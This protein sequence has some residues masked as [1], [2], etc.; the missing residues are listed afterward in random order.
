MR[1]L[2]LFFALAVA[3]VPGQKRDENEPKSE[4]TALLAEP[5]AATRA[6]TAR[7]VF[8][9]SHLS[10]SGLLSKQ[11]SSAL[12]YL[13]DEDAAIVKLRAFVAGSGDVRRVQTLVSEMFT[14]KHRPLPA[15]TVV[16]V[17]ALPVRGA[18][19]QIE[20]VAVEPKREPN[21]DGLAFI[22]A[23][24]A[25]VDRP[26]EAIRPLAEKSLG[27]LADALGAA[28]VSP[29]N[30]LR[31]TC[32]S[33]SVDG[34]D[35]LRERL[36]STYREAAITVLQ[37][38]REPSRTLVGC[39]ATGRLSKR[40]DREIAF[41]GSG[42]SGHSQ[43]VLVRAHELVFTGG[44]LAFG[45]RDEDARLAFQ[46]LGR[47]LEQA[48]TS[49][50]NVV[51]SNTYAL[52][53]RAAAFAEKIRQEFSPTN[54]GTPPAGTAEAFEGLPSLDASFAVEAIAAIQEK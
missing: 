45:V 36:F 38:T 48:G 43:A 41:T 46:R 20:S 24:T 19:V 47:T 33:S 52:S 18:Q 7:L 34:L 12:K 31:I 54:G 50:R 39:E 5:P 51:F 49:Y 17:G 4:V 9:V 8:R 14:K 6:D 3:L 11:T 27:E 21:P 16:H 40:P 13:M 15:L 10:S 22:S 35:Y 28:G 1:R 25:V 53:W 32:F 42:D 44:Q 23:Q 37:Q 2:A 30:A 26:Y 29:G